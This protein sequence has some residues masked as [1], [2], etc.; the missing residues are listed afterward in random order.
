MLEEHLRDALDVLLARQFFYE[1]DGKEHEV[2]LAF[3]HEVVAQVIYTQC[4]AIK[5]SQLHHYIA[6]QLTRYYAN[7]SYTHATEIS[8][9]YRCAGPQYQMQALH[10]EVQ[11]EN[12]LMHVDK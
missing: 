10:Y 7:T 3:V 6:E 2:Y 9:H 8:F 1:Q 4:S 11:V 12:H 5:R